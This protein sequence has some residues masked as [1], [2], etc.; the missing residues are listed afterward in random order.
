M[1][2]PEDNPFELNNQWW[3]WPDAWTAVQGPYEDYVSAHAAMTQWIET[4][5]RARTDN[6]GLD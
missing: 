4:A 6:D 5:K 3:F 2:L 1:P